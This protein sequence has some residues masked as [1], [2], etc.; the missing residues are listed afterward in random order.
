MTLKLKNKLA[1]FMLRSI[2]TIIGLVFANVFPLNAD[3]D[4]V[5]FDT[6]AYR[7]LIL[8]DSKDNKLGYIGVDDEHGEAIML[9]SDNRGEESQL[10]LVGAMHSHRQLWGSNYNN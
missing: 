6:V 5:R 3:F 9:L 8:V 2:C 4:K 7:Q 10:L 1:Y